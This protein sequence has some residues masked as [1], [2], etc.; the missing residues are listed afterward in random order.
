MSGIRRVETTFSILLSLEPYLL[1][2]TSLLELEGRLCCYS[3]AL[4]ILV[5][6]LQLH[7]F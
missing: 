5:D 2:M 7:F 1:F 6:S 3:N 4:H